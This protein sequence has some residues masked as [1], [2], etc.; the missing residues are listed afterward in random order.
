MHYSREV[1]NIIYISPSM[2]PQSG[3]VCRVCCARRQPINEH[4][5][6]ASE[7]SSFRTATSI[8]RRRCGV[9]RFWRRL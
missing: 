2:D 6:V 4:V 7:E 5:Q 9:L 8:T 3:T 1:E